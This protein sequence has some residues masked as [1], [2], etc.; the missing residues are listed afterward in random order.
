MDI[1][2]KCFPQLEDCLAI[3]TGFTSATPGKY[4]DAFSEYLNKLVEFLEPLREINILPTTLT[5]EVNILS[6]MIPVED[7]PQSHF[8]FKDTIGKLSES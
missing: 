8:A 6:M 5:R 2:L 1:L 7:V 4:T 3:Y